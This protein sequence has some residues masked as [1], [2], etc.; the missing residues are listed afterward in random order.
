MELIKDKFVTFIP[1]P[2]IKDLNPT[3]F[4]INF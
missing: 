3:L 1:M 4:N 2:E